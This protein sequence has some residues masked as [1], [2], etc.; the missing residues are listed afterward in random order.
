MKSEIQPH[1][2]RF[3]AALALR[4]WTIQ[5]AR[6]HSF[7]DITRQTIDKYVQA[8]SLSTL[9]LGRLA[10]VANVGIAVLQSDEYW[11]WALRARAA[12]R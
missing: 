5:E 8:R 7:S 4:G 9:Q 10:E 2:R 1:G 12:Q 3:L 6:E 11:P